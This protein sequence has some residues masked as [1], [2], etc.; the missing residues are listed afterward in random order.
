MDVLDRSQNYNARAHLT[1]LMPL[2]Q[3]GARNPCEG[4]PD[5][6][7]RT[8]VCGYADDGFAKVKNPD[9][10]ALSD[11]VFA[12]VKQIQSYVPG[13]QLIVPPILED[14]RIVMM[15]KVQGL[16]DYLP[17]YAGNL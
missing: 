5:S 17:K 16:G 12:R 7:S 15:V 8:A 14:G 10:A 3:D 11:K 9:L 4:D 6:K 13:Y 2:C 1:R